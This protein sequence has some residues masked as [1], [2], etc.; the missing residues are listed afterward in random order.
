VL[1]RISELSLLEPGGITVLEHD[2]R[3][4]IHNIYG[5]LARRST[6]RYGD[7]ALSLFEPTASGTA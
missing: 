3:Q 2:R 6:R 4:E 1:R 7:T 5:A